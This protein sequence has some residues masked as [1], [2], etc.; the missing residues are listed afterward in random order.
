MECKVS[1]LAL[2]KVDIKII[3]A[4]YFCICMLIFLHLV[5]HGIRR[6]SYPFCLWSMDYSFNK[7]HKWRYNFSDTPSG[8][9]HCSHGIEDTSHFLFSCRSHAI[10]RAALVTVVNEIL[11][12]F[13]LTQLVNQSQ[14]YLYG[15]PSLND[16]NNKIIILSTIKYIK[17]TRRFST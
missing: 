11:Y 8:I 5:D 4:I 2:S 14:L 10:R 12:K 13:R 6:V 9:C 16:S 7:G 3:D 15:D 17:E 1:S